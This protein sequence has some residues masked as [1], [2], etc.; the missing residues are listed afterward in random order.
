MKKK[1][2][3]RKKSHRLVRRKGLV[4]SSLGAGRSALRS[5][6]G[7]VSTRAGSDFVKKI[8]RGF[9][10]RPR[11][12]GGT[13]QQHFVRGK[14]LKP[15]R[16]SEKARRLGV[17]GCGEVTGKRRCRWFGVSERASVGKRSGAA[18]VLLER[19]MKG[20]SARSSGLRGP[21]RKRK[22]RE[23]RQGEYG[24]GTVRAWKIKRSLPVRGQRTST[25]G[26]TARRLNGKRG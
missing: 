5:G 21:D 23:S 1:I 2:V 4:S 13:M 8:R 6:R 15:H 17:Y 16:K 20:S 9:P 24:R 18:V 7:F 11:I 25:N 14:P 19:A 22:E 26:K 3:G 10:A 12:G